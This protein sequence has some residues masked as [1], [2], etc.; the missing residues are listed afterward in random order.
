VC[1]P[2]RCHGC[3]PLGRRLVLS[4]SLAARDSGA[5]ASYLMG[6]QAERGER[7]PQPIVP[8]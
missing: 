4:L 6:A 2:L 8:D 1:R 5:F 7:E 3:E